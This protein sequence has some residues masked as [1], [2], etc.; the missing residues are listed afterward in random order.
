M[1]F[2]YLSEAS[3]SRVW[4]LLPQIPGHN[5]VTHVLGLGSTEVEPKTGI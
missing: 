2:L 1:H 3:H 5:I 4:P